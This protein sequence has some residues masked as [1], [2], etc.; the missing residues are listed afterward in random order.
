MRDEFLRSY[1]ARF[2][3]EERGVPT[4]FM[5]IRITRDHHAKTLTI[6]QEK[7]VG[8]ACDKYLNSTCTKSFSSPVLSSKT[9]EFMNITVAKDDVERATMKTKPYMGL[10]GTLLWCV[11]TRPDISYYVSFLCQFMHDP[12]T[13]AWDAGLGVLAYLNS[14]PANWESPTK[15][16]CLS[17]RCSPIPLGGKRLFRSVDMLC[18]SV[19]EP[20][21]TSRGSSR[22]LPN[23]PQKPNTRYTPRP[24]RICDL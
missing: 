9:S 2:N 13:D 10:M 21:L 12:S 24:Q 7:Y 5:G 17:S 15:E 16:T 1:K 6:D 4:K 3:I 14:S 8:E 19:G 22:S 23:H 11:F 18:S 20:F